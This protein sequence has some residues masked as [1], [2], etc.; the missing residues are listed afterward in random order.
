MNATLPSLD[1]I[2]A[3]EIALEISLILKAVSMLTYLCYRFVCCRAEPHHMR[4]KFGGI[5]HLRVRPSFVSQLVRIH[6]LY[7][8]LTPFGREFEFAQP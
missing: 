5:G 3:I 7:S 1:C 2:T 4:R 8:P 6:L